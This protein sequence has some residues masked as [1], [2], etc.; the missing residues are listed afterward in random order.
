MADNPLSC[1][2]FLVLL[3]DIRHFILPYFWYTL[4]YSWLSATDSF[5]KMS[6]V[7]LEI[8][9]VLFSEPRSAGS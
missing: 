4:V 8:N 7:H 5:L 1:L 6:C 9:C 3:Y 2:K